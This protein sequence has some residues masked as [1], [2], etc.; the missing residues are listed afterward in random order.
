MSKDKNKD[1]TNIEYNHLNLP[2][3]VQFATT[4]MTGKYI[5]YT[6]DATGVKLAKT[7]QEEGLAYKTSTYY[8][9]AYI[10]EQLPGMGISIQLKFISHPEG[11][12]EPNNQGGYDYIFHYKDHLGNIR[13]SYKDTN[14]NGS[15][16]SSEIK[17]ENNYYPFGL[18]HKG[19]NNV[20]NGT[21]YPY[22]YLACPERSRRRKEEN[23]ELGLEWLDFG[24]RN[25]DASLGRWMN[26]DPKA[27]KYYQLSPYQAMANNP[28]VFVD[29]DGEDII[30]VITGKIVKM[31]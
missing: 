26:I 8:S 16:D 25:Y 9:G 23:D 29:P 12:I 17:E 27:D 22:G 31:R 28:I 30:I 7:V 6:Y 1:I 20:V 19:Y 21:D 4:N 24:A 18:K 5:E 14:N 3:K 13:L 15:V 11:Y 2:K 10:Y